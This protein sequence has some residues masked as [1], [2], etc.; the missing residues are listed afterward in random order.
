MTA[1]T[2][3]AGRP[4]TL[5]AAEITSEIPVARLAT[6]HPATIRVFQKHDIDFCCGGKRPLAEA[7]AERGVDFET[8]RAELARV[9]EG[10]DDG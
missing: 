3:G 2:T 5:T 4:T 8:L 10:E 6:L 7:C 9:G 1:Q